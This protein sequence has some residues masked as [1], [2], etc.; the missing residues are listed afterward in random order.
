ML[1]DDTGVGVDVVM[2]SVTLTSVF[3]SDSRWVI[4]GEV[5]TTQPEST[6]FNCEHDY[7]DVS[8]LF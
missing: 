7:D 3:C 2:R 4:G 1:S 8:W 5:A 6:I